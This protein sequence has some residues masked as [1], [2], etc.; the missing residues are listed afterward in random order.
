MLI[1]LNSQFSYNA[2]PI[3]MNLNTQQGPRCQLYTPDEIHRDDL[4]MPAW[5]EIHNSNYWDIAV[6]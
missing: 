4:S 6:G 2:N 3:T 5:L 1:K